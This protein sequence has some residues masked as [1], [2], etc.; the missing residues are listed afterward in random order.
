MGLRVSVSVA[1]LLA[2]VESV[3]PVGAVMV[4]VLARV[5]VAVARTVGVERV[6]GGGSDGEVDGVGD[7]AG[8]AGGA[9]GA[10]GGD[11]GPC[12]GGEGGRDGVGDV[13]PTTAEGPLLV[14]TIVYDT[15]VPGT[16]TSEPS[17]LVIVRSA[18]TLRV[19]VSVAVLLAGVDSVTPVGA[20][21]VA[22][23]V[24][25]A[26]GR[27]PNVGGERVRRGGP[28]GEVDSVGDATG[29]AGRA[30]WHRSKRHRSTLHS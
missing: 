21:I 28:D 7:V 29:S 25:D 23:L 3:T 17:V 16:S 20:V 11:A 12:G 26:G 1:V 5:P 13:A 14:A 15:G 18:V 19:S 4:A 6:G 22:V 2:G 8:S 10:A 30:R 24:S 9:G 27:G